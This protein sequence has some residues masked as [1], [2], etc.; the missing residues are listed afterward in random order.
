MRFF[1]MIALILLLN[2]AYNSSG[3]SQY[4]NNGIRWSTEGNAYYKTEDHNIIQF[5]L[6]DNQ[7]TIIVS[8]NMLVPEGM[9]KPLN[10]AAFSFSK[11]HQK[12]LIYTNTKKVS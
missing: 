2:L 5:S 7:Q 1:S 8:K 3:F 12:L 9:E 4:N 11:D 6:P 10:I